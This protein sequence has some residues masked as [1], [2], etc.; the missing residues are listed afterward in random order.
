MNVS[1]V[2]L[3]CGAGG[4]THGFVKEGLRVTAGIDLDS[5]CKF[6]YEKNNDSIFYERDV[7]SISIEELNNMF[8]GA[9]VKI[10]A[11]CAP[12]Q[13]FSNYSNR[14]DINRNNRWSLL[15]EFSRLIKGVKPD[16]ITMENVPSVQKHEVF[17][18]FVGQLKEYGYQVWYQIIDS[19]HY[20]IPQTR[21]RLVLLAS[22]HGD[23]K[24]IERTH[25]KPRTVKQA[26]G[27][28]APIAAGESSKHDRL[29]R[30]AS[31]SEL[32]IQ[33][34]K[35]SKPGGTWRDWPEE[36]VA[37][38]HKDKKGKTYSSVYGRMEWDKPAP[39]MTTQCYGFGNGRF[40]HPE[41]NR[42]ISLREAAI[43]QSFPRNYKFLDRGQ[44]VNVNSLGR[45]IG[46]AV[47]VG[48]GEAI[49]KSIKVHLEEYGKDITLN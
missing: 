14:Y 24:M 23:I 30:A 46:N 15:N 32:N 27:R 5:A 11:G 38:C 4:L 26:I 3:F 37:E 34:I 43:I 33:R 36:L 47:P 44:E 1:C 19:T 31:L 9:Q 10:L 45:M 7:S 20:G 29:H 6:P 22:L 8:G 2:D 41:Q 28:L 25:L 12:C 13:P 17:S 21:K 16:V 35:S 40:G 49:A 42:A 48:L 39:T 18:D